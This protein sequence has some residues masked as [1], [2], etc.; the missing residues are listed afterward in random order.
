M[1]EIKMNVRNKQLDGSTEV[2]EV[3]LNEDNELES[4]NSVEP[5]PNAGYTKAE[6]DA[7]FEKKALDIYSDPTAQID[8][9]T[10]V[11]TGISG[12]TFNQK[13]DIILERTSDNY[14]FGTGVYYEYSSDYNEIICT[15]LMSEV[16][17]DNDAFITAILINKETNVCMFRNG[18]GMKNIVFSS[19]KIY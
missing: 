12:L 16:D 2:S 10:K 18:D 9:N 15:P 11:I 17:N 4:E 14:I 13:V 1:E 7:K 8:P 5:N 6:A 3:T 19:L